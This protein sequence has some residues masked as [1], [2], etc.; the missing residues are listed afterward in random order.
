M[1]GTLTGLK[2][3]H[4][5]VKAISQIMDDK[6][7]A[8]VTELLA[9]VNDP[10]APSAKAFIRVKGVQFNTIPVLNFEHGSIVEEE[11]PFVFSDYEFL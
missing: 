5:L 2:I 4:S 6:K 7:G 1:S 8:F 11:L 10:E 9:E 3:N